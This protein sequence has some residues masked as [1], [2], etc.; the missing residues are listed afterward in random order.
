MAKIAFK[1]V[2]DYIAA[3][4]EAVQPVLV[5]VRSAIRKAVPKAEEVISYKMP[6]YTIGGHPVLYFASW[7]KHYS[8]YPVTERLVAAC[9]GTPAACEVKKGT[10]RFPLNEPVPVKLVEQIAKLRAKEV[11]T[12]QPGD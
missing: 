5:R 4:P 10:I 2:D 8:L 6:A 7:K 3:Q 12:K 11:A 1:S 9:K